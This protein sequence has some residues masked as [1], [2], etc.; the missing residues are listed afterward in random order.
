[1]KTSLNK[2]VIKSIRKVVG[3]G[4]HELHEPLFCGN[5]L[6]YLKKTITTNSV[7]SIG[8]Y[9][10][11][12]EE[13]IKSLTKS[14]FAIAVVNGTTALHISLK[15][16]GV[17]NDDEVL[18]PALTF[19]GTANAAVHCGAIPHFIDS[20][21]STMGIDP[22]KLEQYLNQ[23]VIFKKNLAI[24]KFTKRVI[25][26][27]VPVHIFGHPCRIDEIIKI[28]KK[29]NL[30]VIEDAAEALGSYYKKKH[31]GTF[32]LA[33]CL[34]FNGDK[35]VTTGGGGAVITNN[36][37]LARKIR[38]LSNTAK[39]PHKWEYIHDQIGYNFRMPNLNAALGLAQLEN[40]NI[41]VKAKRNLYKL[42]FSAFKNVKDISVYK[43][44]KKAKSNY[45]LQTLILK[46]NYYLFKKK[47]L[48]ECHKSGLHLRPAWK[49]ISN[50]K[51]FKHNPRMDLTGSKEIYKSIINLPSGQSLL[52]KK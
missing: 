33:G 9:V 7:S 20:E 11:K 50:L 48:K 27:I 15:V 47:I 26:A 1:M 6:R 5:E 45:W 10:K 51:P 28:A 49:L 24:N 34:S 22:R 29:F 23:I 36:N 3:K 43:E 39:L 37:A 18:I 38:H 12:F 30:L 32:G 17:K 35:I 2:I 14:K 40:I 8:D 16:A 25:R 13:K 4:N 21:I 44:I 19:V 52:I 42:Y 46:K 41:F 31:L